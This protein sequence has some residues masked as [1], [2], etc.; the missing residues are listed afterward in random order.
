MPLTNGTGNRL[1]TTDKVANDM[2]LR[3]KNNLVLTKS[4]YRDLEGQF[5]QIGDAINVRLPNNVIVND[6]RVATTT[7]PLNDKTITLTIDTQK[8]VKFN[9]TMKDKKLSIIEFGQRYLEP[10]ANRLANEVDISVANAMLTAYTPFGT[11]GQ[12]LK[13]TD[14]TMGRAYARDIA[15]P[16]D[17]LVRLIVNT[18]DWANISNGLST[19][20]QQNLVR[21]AI[22]KGYA[23]QLAGFDMFYSQNLVTHTNGTFSGSE[24]VATA[25]ANG[26]QLAISGGTA[27]ATIKKGDRF[28]IAGVGEINPITKQP[29]GRLQTF[30]VLEDV[31]LDAS[32]N[33]TLTISPT[34][35]DGTGTTTDGS[36]AT[37]TTAMD[38]NVTAG[39][40][41]GAAITFIGDSGG[42]YRENY[43]MHRNAVAMAFVF[44]DLPA[45]GHGSR[46][47]DK[48]TGL[49]I[50]VSE[51]FDGDNNENNLRMD[52]L[53]GVKMVRPDLIL[54]ATCQKIG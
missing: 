2:L 30:V 16:D 7:T 43:I 4:V 29:T 15:I 36:G 3:W 34:I 47:R 8:N 18:I 22:V 6:G 25:L 23:G 39:A 48:Q 21:D 51:Y 35:N 17:A 13:Y 11:A 37:I 32:G 49:S 44:L 38:K 40:A 54:R 14:I 45:S 53:Y 33:G 12:E 26:N 19:I 52:I 46:A 31:T 1:L 41:S 42:T 27:S 28:S 10:A 9:W 50:S 5:G 24:Q 20:Q